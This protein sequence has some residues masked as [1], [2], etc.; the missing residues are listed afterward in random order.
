MPHSGG[1]WVTVRAD[2]SMKLDVQLTLETEDGAHILVT[3]HGIGVRQAD[4]TV[5]VHPAPLFEKGDGRY[6]WLNRVQAVGIGRT[7]EGG[8]MYDVYAP[9]EPAAG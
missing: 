5:Q 6:A 7:V 1:D 8:V 2:G 3:Y 4:G 9:G